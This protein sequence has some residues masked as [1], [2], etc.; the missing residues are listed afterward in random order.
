MDI[1]TGWKWYD[2]QMYGTDPKTGEQVEVFPGLRGVRAELRR[3]E[4][5]HMLLL[6]PFV[7]NQYNGPKEMIEDGFKAMGLVEKIF[8]ACVRG[9]DGITIDG[10]TPTV[11]QIAKEPALVGFVWGVMNKLVQIGTLTADESKN[12][13]GP[14][15]SSGP[16]TSEASPER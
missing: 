1:L 11:E 15:G 8:P 6:Y 7:G 2:V 13:K 16:E 9:I 4:V 12:S 3:P 14:S 5:S 10:Q